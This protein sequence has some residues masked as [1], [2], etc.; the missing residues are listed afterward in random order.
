MAV[1]PE[2]EGSIVLKE[3]FYRELGYFHIMCS[4]VDLTVDYAIAKFLAV[5]AEDVHLMTPGMSF[6]RKGKLLADLIGRSKQLDKAKRAKLLG[7][8]NALRAVRR[9]AVTHSYIWASKDEIKFIERKVTGDFR[10]IEYCYTLNEF[11]AFVDDF[12]KKASIFDKELAAPPAELNAFANSA[13]SLDRKSK[14]SP[15]KPAD[16]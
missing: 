12:A 3:E 7:A 5:P 6:G 11:K 15:A 4:I 14:R 1:N 8:I 2:L 10:A 16:K 13:L 9:D